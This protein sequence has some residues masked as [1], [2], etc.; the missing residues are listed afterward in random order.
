MK[1]KT[2]IFFIV[3]TLVV[4][5]LAVIPIIRNTEKTVLSDASRQ[6]APG[7][8]VTLSNGS[9]HYQIDGPA[10]GQ[11]VILV[12]GFSVPMYIYDSTF[13]ALSSVG[14]RVIRFD[15]LG[16]GYSSRPKTSYDLQLFV[17]QVKELVDTLQLS[18]PVDLIGVSMGGTIVAGFVSKYPDLVR[19]V[20]LI[21]PHSTKKNVTPLNVPILGEYLAAA[22]WIQTLPQDQLKDFY[23]PDQHKD[24]PARF[25]EQMRYKGF[26]YAI[27]STARNIICNDFLTSYESL[28]DLP[29]LL[30]WGTHDKTIPIAEIDTLRKLI[31]P[32]FLP[33]DNAGH[34]PLI[35][36]SEIVNKRLIEFLKRDYNK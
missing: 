34:L 29:V 1:R 9:T 10:N 23:Q 5:I 19:K 31:N 21:D 26:R 12:H 20:V 2:K 6:K 16:R 33:V 25:Q 8:F 32:E 11:V 13:N 18:T 3:L 36:Q 27:V 35:E 22:F 30:I 14:Y 28:S 7:N 17:Q 24:W 15:L 4:C